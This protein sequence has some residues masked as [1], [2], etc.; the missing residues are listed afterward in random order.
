MMLCMS[1]V[2]RWPIYQ[3]ETGEPFNMLEWYNIVGGVGALCWLVAY[4]IVIRT[5]QRQQT[6]GIP[7]VA[8]SL[9]LTWELMDS[10]FLPD[11]IPAWVWL[12]RSWFIVDVLIVTQLFRYGRR[13]Q[14]LASVRQHFLV[15]VLSV[16]LLAFVGQYSW[17]TTFHDTL[18]IILAFVINLIMSV[19]FVFFYFSRT[20]SGGQGLI[21]SVAWLKM[22]GTALSSV[23]CYFLLPQIHPIDPSTTRLPTYS[24]FYFLFVGCFLFDC[25][26]IY[27]V[28]RGE[29]TKSQ[30]PINREPVQA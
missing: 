1:P 7:L 16:L 8:I 22:L 6:Y 4:L 2:G 26:Y 19:L 29:R 3:L 20:A 5:C 24:F 10:F 13:W 12:D 18:G 17:V 15:V 21:T 27:L 11:P 14:Q 9:N 30:A 28:Q 25:L 23:Q